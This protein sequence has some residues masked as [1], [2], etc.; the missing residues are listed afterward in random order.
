M[1]IG[2]FHSFCLLCYP[3][4]AESSTSLVQG[5]YAANV[6][7]FANEPGLKQVIPVYLKAFC[8]LLS[9]NTI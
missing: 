2:Q 5:R 1:L 3:S 9:P 4:S 6:H 7:S 8:S